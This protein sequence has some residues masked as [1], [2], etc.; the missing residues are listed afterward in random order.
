[1]IFPGFGLGA[2]YCVIID[3]KGGVAVTGDSGGGPGLGFSL[4]VTGGI[5]ASHGENAHDQG[6]PFD[7]G[8]VSIGPA[9]VC[10]STGKSCE[11][12]IWSFYVG[13][14]KSWGLP[15]GGWFGELSTKVVPLNGAEL[16]R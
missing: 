9:E 10:I 11:K 4:G 15:F 8:D 14:R 2:G 6:G 5:V 3:G 13:I 7:T 1:V 16:T 12:G